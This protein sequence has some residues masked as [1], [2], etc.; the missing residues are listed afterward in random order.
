VVVWSPQATSVVASAVL[1]AAAADR[2]AIRAMAA[3]RTISTSNSTLSTSA[4]GGIAATPRADHLPA[5]AWATLS[6]KLTPAAPASSSLGQLTS[7][8]RRCR[9]ALSH[10]SAPV[11]MTMNEST[12]SGTAHACSAA[13]PP[14]VL[15]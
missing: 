12:S 7:H 4:A 10:R 9:A 6:R 3:R 2:R 1:V 14:E 5:P 8:Q 11:A 13:I 15:A